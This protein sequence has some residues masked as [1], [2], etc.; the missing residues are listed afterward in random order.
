M[1]EKSQWDLPYR[2]PAHSV[3]ECDDVCEGATPGRVSTHFATLLS[4]H[5]GDVTEKPERVSSETR[6][7]AVL[8]MS[9]LE[10]CGDYN[11][12][13][14]KRHLN[15]AFAHPLFIYSIIY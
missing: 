8:V 6:D 7:Q 9:I 14:N 1:Q 4:P 2:R 13:N 12:E 11:D 5:G 15:L 10:P 3:I